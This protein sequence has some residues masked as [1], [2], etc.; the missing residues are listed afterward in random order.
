MTCKATSFYFRYFKLHVALC[1]QSIFKLFWKPLKPNKLFK[2]KHLDRPALN[3]QDKQNQ[4]VSRSLIFNVVV[5]CL[6]AHF[7]R[8]W[9]QNRGRLMS[10]LFLQRLQ[11]IYMQQK[12]TQSRSLYL[13]QSIVEHSQERLRYFSIA[14]RLV[15]DKFL[16][17]EV[18]ILDSFGDF[19]RV[20]WRDWSSPIP[21]FFETRIKLWIEISTNQYCSSQRWKYL[22][23]ASFGSHFIKKT[24]F[25]TEIES[26]GTL[27]IYC[28]L[29][30]SFQ[31]SLIVSLD[32]Q[33]QSICWE[34][35]ILYKWTF[36]SE[37]INMSENICRFW[38]PN[39]FAHLHYNVCNENKTN[40]VNCCRSNA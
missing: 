22:N 40:A 13:V 21:L 16:L 5:S 6:N 15:N 36:K 2:Q 28:T 39:L 19:V 25:L 20:E 33:Y 24:A 35:W 27:S 32:M 37:K 8:F 38:T 18:K 12:C 7:Q 29:F 4:K 14:S 30:E 31:N 9:W 1:T 17:L 3:Q 10:K 34:L 11:S 23:L 26:L